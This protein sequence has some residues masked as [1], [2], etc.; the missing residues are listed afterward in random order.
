MAGYGWRVIDGRVRMAG[1]G[2]RG[3]DG[4]VRMAGKVRMV[5]MSCQQLLPVMSTE[6]SVTGEV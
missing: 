1:S 6:H 5:R 2:W 4:R 3:R